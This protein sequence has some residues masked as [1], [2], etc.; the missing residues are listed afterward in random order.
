M[1]RS[2]QKPSNPKPKDSKPLNNY[3]RYSGLAFQMATTIGVMAYIGWKLDQWL[4]LDFPAFF[5]VFVF[6]SFGGSFYL[7]VKGLN[8]GN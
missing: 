4:Q 5:L 8:R 2:P 6:I 7:L 1:D 3:L